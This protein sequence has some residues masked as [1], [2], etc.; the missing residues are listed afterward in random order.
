MVNVQP[1]NEK[2]VD[3]AR[4][5]V[6][7]IAAVSYEEAASLLHQAGSVRTAIV[8]HKLNLTRAQAEAKLVAAHGRLRTALES[9][10]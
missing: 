5:I 7:S 2:L 4:R 9:T 3:R 8:M 1:T 10:R 6:S